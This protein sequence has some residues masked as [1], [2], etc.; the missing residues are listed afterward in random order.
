[1]P[2]TADGP[3]PQH[4][5][6]LR[7]TAKTRSFCAWPSAAN[8]DGSRSVGGS[9]KMRPTCRGVQLTFSGVV[10]GRADVG[11]KDLR[12]AGEEYGGGSGENNFT[13]YGTLICLFANL[14][15][16]AFAIQLAGTPVRPGAFGPDSVLAGSI[17]GDEPLQAEP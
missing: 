1:M 7:R 13:F 10:L 6:P 4:V 3:R 15:V 8:R 11:R 14:G 2:R 5:G 16:N 9:P 12:A 17:S